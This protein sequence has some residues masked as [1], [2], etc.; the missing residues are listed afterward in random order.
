M[1]NPESP[2]EVSG[3]PDSLTDQVPTPSL[4]LVVLLSAM[5]G[6]M[7]WGIRGQYGHETG[8]MI[9]GALVG[10]VLAFFFC[11]RVSSLFTARA[12]ALMTVAIGFGGSMTYGQTVGLTHDAPLIGNTDAL[13]WG[14]VGLFIKGGL[15]IAFA[16]AFLGI[17]LS[18]VDYKPTEIA[19]LLVLMVFL[20]FLGVSL[21][22]HPFDPAEKILPNVYFSDHWFW[23]PDS[24]LKPRPERWGG[25]FFA[26]VGVLIYVSI[27]KRDKLAQVLTLFGFL[28]GGF[29]FSLGQ[30]VQAYHA[31]HPEVFEAGIFAKASV[32]QVISHF[33]WWNMMET[34]FGA[35]FGAIL[36]LGVWLNRG[37]IRTESSKDQVEMSPANEWLLVLVHVAALLAWN[38][39]NYPA[40]DQFAGH[41]ITMGLLPIFG[42]VAGRYWPFLITLP[43]VIL[44]IAGKTIRQLV[45]GTKQIE[46]PLGW[47]VYGVV[48]VVLALIIALI[49]IYRS[50]HGQTGRNFAR[51][52]L[53]YAAWAF[54][55]LNFAF[56]DFSWP[57]APLE[58]WTGRTPN[59]AIFGVCLIVI[60]LMTLVYGWR[61]ARP[62][63]Q[64]PQTEDPPTEA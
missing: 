47:A 41:A 38:F 17:G 64:V 43:I 40:L 13:T 46:E 57:W 50:K 37:L 49:Q 61:S 7:G 12:V 45:Y 24:E 48:P 16:G 31:W 30:S 8:A 4:F 14:M 2:L 26:L 22:N 5:A 54:F 10:L 29:G 55:C 56:F 23:E 11:P 52:A 3:N 42:I 25:L 35:V 18:R 6:G 44:P 51:W 60:T 28:A 59:A 32:S 15:W 53:L 21:I 36:G 39:L 9:A 33:N 19:S 27:I 1:S 62:I 34:T 20:L 63:V 58:D